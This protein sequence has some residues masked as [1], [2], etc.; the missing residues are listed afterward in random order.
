MKVIIPAKASSTRVPDKNWREFHGGKSLVDLNI[1]AMIRCGFTPSDIHVSCECHD[2]L[3]RVEQ[4]HGITPLLRDPALCGNDV[5]LTDWIRGLCSQVPG[6]CDV[7][8]SQVCDPLFTE[9]RRLVTDWYSV[10][11]CGHD[12]YCVVHPFKA[13]LLDEAKR[14]IGW[15]FGEWHTPSQ[16]L[17]Q[18]YTFPFTMSILTRGAI[19]RTG[20]HIGAKPAWFVSKGGSIDIDTMEDFELARAK[21]AA[22]QP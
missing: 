1:E 15:Q 13:Y 10:K 12:S 19:A 5:P 4:R 20:Y 14:P 8:W 21:Y 3:A 18:L 11:A 22:R 2:K 16:R 7:V 17:P 6:E 9:H